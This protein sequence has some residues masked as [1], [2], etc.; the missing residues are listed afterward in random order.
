MSYM[1]GKYYA[2]IG[3]HAV[4]DECPTC[5]KGKCGEHD[6]IMINELE[7]PL[8]IFDQL[9]VMRYAEMLEDGIAENVERST[10]TKQEGN[11]GSWALQRKLGLDPA[12]SLKSYLDR[13]VKK[14]DEVSE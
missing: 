11:F 7:L 14:R 8:N 1:R 3:S 4:P 2:W 9:V 12:Q 13:V 6:Y 10:M 5:Q